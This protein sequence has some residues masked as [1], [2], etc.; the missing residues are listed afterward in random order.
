MKK[1][2]LTSTI[3]FACSVLWAV[4]ALIRAINSNIALCVAY[5]GLSATF[6]TLGIMYKRRSKDD[7]DNSEDE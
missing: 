4:S 3:Y 1:N 6:F 2:K 5:I 7:P